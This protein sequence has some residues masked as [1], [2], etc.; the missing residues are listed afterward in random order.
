M[1]HPKLF[2]LGQMRHA[3]DFFNLVVAHVERPE[4]GLRCKLMLRNSAV[5]GQRTL[6]SSPSIFVNPLWLKYSSSRLTSASRPSSLVMRF[7]CIDRI[8]S[9]VNVSRFYLVSPLP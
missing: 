7:D 2:Q 4:L 1:T 5:L 6:L 8:L 9:E 3:L